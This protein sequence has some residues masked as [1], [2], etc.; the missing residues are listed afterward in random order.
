MLLVLNGSIQWSKMAQSSLRPPTVPKGCSGSCSFGGWVGGLFPDYKIQEKKTNKQKKCLL[1]KE[2]HSSINIQTFQKVQSSWCYRTNQYCL[3]SMLWPCLLMSAWNWR[4][5]NI[6][7][8]NISRR[9]IGCWKWR[10]GFVSKLLLVIDVPLCMWN[11]LTRFTVPAW[12]QITIY[13]IYLDIKRQISYIPVFKQPSKYSIYTFTQ[14]QIC[15]LV[16]PGFI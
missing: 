12:G 11:N 7:V 5:A 10:W 2:S 9:F 8:V 15:K 16:L 6:T 13:C 4:V 1:P 3:M 14:M